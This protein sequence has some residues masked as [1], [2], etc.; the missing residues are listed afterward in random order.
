MIMNAFTCPE[1]M[2]AFPTGDALKAHF[3][4]GHG[5]GEGSSAGGEGG[6][7]GGEAGGEGGAGEAP[8]ARRASLRAVTAGV[9]RAVRRDKAEQ[10][11]AS[12][13]ANLR[14]ERGTRA[15]I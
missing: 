12:A 8:R 13:S 3:D 11:I 6:L 10:A 1:C 4:G 7:E 5:T 15:R 9:L 2:A 14:C